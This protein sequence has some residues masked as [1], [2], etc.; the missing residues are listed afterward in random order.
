[1]KIKS[2]IFDMDGTLLDSMEV[3]ETLFDRFLQSKNVV[4]PPNIREVIRPMSP[5]QSAEYF[6]QEFSLSGSPTEILAEIYQ[7]VEDW[8]FNHVTPKVDAVQFLDKLKN[9]G[10]K[11]CVATSTPTYLA[12]AGLQ[13]NDMLKYFS[14]IYTTDDV[15]IAKDNPKFYNYVADSEGF[16]IAET[17][18]FEDAFFAVESA[19]NAGFRV[20]AI[21]ESSAI[22]QRDNIIQ[23]ADMYIH[24]YTELNNII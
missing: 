24:S 16:K 20:V 2:A 19:Q 14:K 13:R 21:E 23:I 3:W 18:V 12:T 6:K 15:G 4:P 5:L 10:I 22:K 7:M 1:M 17:L 9:N 11:M 8:Y